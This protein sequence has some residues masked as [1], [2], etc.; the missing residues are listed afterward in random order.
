MYLAGCRPI[1]QTEHGVLKEQCHELKYCYKYSQ[2][3][4][5]K[6]RF[7][8]QYTEFNFCH[9]QLMMT[10]IEGLKKIHSIVSKV[11]SVMRRWEVHETRKYQMS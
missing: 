8:C 4:G 7:L 9:P 2:S 3:V 10:S 1:Y 5:I 11:T 6:A